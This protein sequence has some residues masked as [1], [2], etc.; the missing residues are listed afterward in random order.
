MELPWNR[1]VDVPRIYQKFHS[2]AG[3]LPNAYSDLVSSQE[4]PGGRR[5]LGLGI[6]LVS[7]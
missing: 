3:S 5:G 4:R 2:L 6:G 7:G 1:S